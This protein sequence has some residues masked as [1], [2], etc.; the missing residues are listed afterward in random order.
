MK[1]S[2]FGL[3]HLQ[4]CK[5]NRHESSGGLSAG[6]VGVSSC[7]AGRCKKADSA[8]RGYK[9]RRIEHGE[10]CTSGLSCCSQKMK[11]KDSMDYEYTVKGRPRRTRN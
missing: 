1:G 9:G 11:E 5:R 4:L 7:M 6:V 10:E 8:E 3:Q 2:V